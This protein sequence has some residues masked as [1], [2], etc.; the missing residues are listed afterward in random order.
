[1]LC[2]SPGLS[3]ARGWLLMVTHVTVT[4]LSPSSCN[5]TVNLLLFEDF[6]SL[7]SWLLE[8]CGLAKISAFA[9]ITLSTLPVYG[10]KKLENG[11][12][13]FSVGWEKR[14]EMHQLLN[15]NNDFLAASYQKESIREHGGVTE[16]ETP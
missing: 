10:K 4:H 3:Y 6:F 12:P 14:G 9:F 16:R 5:L 11:I 1:M 13:V 7:V 2:N 15:N 8:A